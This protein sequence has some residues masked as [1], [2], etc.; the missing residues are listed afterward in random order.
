[1]HAFLNYITEFNAIAT[2]EIW[3]SAFFYLPF[4]IDPALEIF[5]ICFANPITFKIQH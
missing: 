1:M 3:C 4:D 5:L 2:Q